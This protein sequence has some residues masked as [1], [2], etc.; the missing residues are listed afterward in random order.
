DLSSVVNDVD[1]IFVAVGTPPKPDGSADMSATLS[2]VDEVC[3]HAKKKT[4]LVLKSTVPVGTAATLNERCQKK[5]SAEI[6]IIN[7]PE[8]LKE[9]RA[10]EDFMKPD[11]VVI[12]CQTVEAQE[13][14][15]KL[16]SPFVRG[17]RP[18]YFMSNASAELC[19]YAA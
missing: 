13:L 2:V 4:F 18:I 12:G 10:V 15:T 5:S 6:E 1:V 14:M 9:G 3:R 11:R 7:N 19:K 8:F 17:V 16:Y